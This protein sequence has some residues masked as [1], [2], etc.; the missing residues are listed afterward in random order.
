MVARCIDGA[1][2]V[3]VCTHAAHALPMF[4]EEHPKSLKRKREKARSD[5]KLSHK[6]EVPVAGKGQEYLVPS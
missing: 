1:L 4:R 2:C 5:P 6:P 3:C